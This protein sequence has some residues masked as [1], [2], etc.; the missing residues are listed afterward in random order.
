MMEDK[1]KRNNWTRKSIEEAKKKINKEIYGKNRQSS[2]QIKLDDLAIYINDRIT[3]HGIAK[4]LVFIQEDLNKK[5]LDIEKITLSILFSNNKEEQYNYL[6]EVKNIIRVELWTD[7][8]FLMVNKAITPGEVTDLIRRSN[9]I[10]SI[11]DKWISSIEMVISAY[12]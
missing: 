7:I 2:L 3:R 12:G 1:N 5:I 9:E 8:R 6:L 10:E 11:I 4:G